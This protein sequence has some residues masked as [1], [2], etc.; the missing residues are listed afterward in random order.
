MPPREGRDLARVLLERADGDVALVRYVCDNA[1]IPDAI[2]GFHAQ[3]AVEKSLKAVLAAHDIDYTKTH[4]LGYLIGLVQTNGIDAP[5]PVL[6][7]AELN[8]WAVEFRYETD[9][10]PALDR[11]ATLELIEDIRRWAEGEIRAQED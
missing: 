2:V 7:A 4:L 8:P 11:L 1:D 3:Q 9:S 6:E 10:E 5:P